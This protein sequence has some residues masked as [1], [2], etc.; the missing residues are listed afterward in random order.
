MATLIVEDGT[1]SNSNA[2]SY[3]DLAFARDF[4][5]N[6][7]LTLSADD[8]E[9]IQNLLGAMPYI[10]SRPYQGQRA[11]ASQPLSWPRKLVSADGYPVPENVVPVGIKRAQVVASAM[12]FGGVDLLP[13]VSAGG[14]ITK[15]KVG[16]IETEYSDKFLNTW[17][18]QNLFTAIDVYLLPFMNYQSGYKLSPMFGF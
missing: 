1:G 8:N 16:P 5:E 9:A 15:E 12:V 10:E 7:N 2:N 18:G 14:A 4:A 3:V 17:N 6:M 11:T 13:T